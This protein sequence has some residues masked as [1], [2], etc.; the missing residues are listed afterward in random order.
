MLNFIPQVFSL[1]FIDFFLLAVFGPK[2]ESR[3]FYLIFEREPTRTVI[4]IFL[5]L[6]LHFRNLGH[7][8]QAVHS[9]QN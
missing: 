6:K 8:S 4:F 5:R 9:V 2:A 1:I 3:I 7:A